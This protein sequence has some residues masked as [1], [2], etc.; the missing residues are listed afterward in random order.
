MSVLAKST[1]VLGSI[2]LLSVC[3][4]RSRHSRQQSTTGKPVQAHLWEQSQDP[5]SGLFGSVSFQSFYCRWSCMILAW[6]FV[7]LYVCSIRFFSPCIQ[8]VLIRFVLICLIALTTC[9]SHLLSFF[10]TC[11]SFP[12]TRRS[13]FLVSPSVSPVSSSL[14]SLTRL[15]CLTLITCVSFTCLPLSQLCFSA[16]SVSHI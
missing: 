2:I 3:C 12:L 8:L 14:S 9:V 10:L 1:T 15:F 4:M 6:T 13:L 5:G 7:C 16:S 11:V